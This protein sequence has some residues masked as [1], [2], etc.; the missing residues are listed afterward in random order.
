MNYELYHHGV[1]GMKWGVR[2]A[3]K[4]QAKAKRA[5]ESADE[6]D[7]IANHKESAG[8]TKSAAKYRSYAA[9]DRRDAD[10][11]ERKAEAIRTGKKQSI[12]DRAVANVKKK[13][14]KENAVKA[15][16]KGAEVCSKMALAS[17]VD[18]IYYGGAGKKIAKETIK[19][20]GRAVVTAYTMANGGYDIRWYDK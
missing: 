18:D 3:K 6:W 5:R 1:K 9:K 4:Y 7:E 2:R 19:Q 14:T 10:K 8:K 15:V 13:V 11:Y 12:K 20:T 16:A 17:A